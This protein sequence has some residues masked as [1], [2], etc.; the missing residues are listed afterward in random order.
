MAF[1]EVVFWL[2]VRRVLAL[3]RAEEAR[4]RRKAL[5]GQG[6]EAVQTVLWLPSSMTEVAD[7]LQICRVPR[8]VGALTAYASEDG[9]SATIDTSAYRRSRAGDESDR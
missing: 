9:P 7:Y 5:T 6:L 4:S 2:N 8:A 1:V 3:I